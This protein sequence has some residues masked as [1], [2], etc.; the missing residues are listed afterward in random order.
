MFYAKVRPS[1]GRYE[2]LATV[3]LHGSTSMIALLGKSNTGLQS[4]SR[5]RTLTREPL[6]VSGQELLTLAVAGFVT[7]AAVI[8]LHLDLKVSGHAILRSALPLMVGL[9]LVP[10]RFAGSTMSAMA[11]LSCLGMLALPGT[12]L[13]LAAGASMVL[14][15]PAIDLA[16]VGGSIAKNLYLRFA[17]AG[18]AA[19]LLALAIK[20]GAAAVWGIGGTGRSSLAPID[21]LASY[22]LCGALAGV[23]CGALVFRNSPPA[24]DAQP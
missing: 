16:L 20:F 8:W 12:R 7:A 18:A 4:L 9:A 15:G 13:P 10:R 19:N 1:V 5:I 3:F 23:L 11:L 22:L 24:E 6:V 14:L 17:V 2:K 21:T